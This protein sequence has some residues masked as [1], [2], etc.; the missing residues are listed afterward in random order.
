MAVD[1]DN[2]PADA[3]A[4]RPVEVTRPRD[5]V[6]PDEPAARPPGPPE[7]GPELRERQ[8]DEHARYRVVVEAT[9]KA[10][11]ARDEWERGSAEL[12]R[13]WEAYKERYPAPERQESRTEPDGS[14]IGDG[15]RRLSPEQNAEADKYAADLREEAVGSIRPAMER[16]QASDPGRKLAGLEHMLKG[17]DRLKEKLADDLNGY[18]EQ[19]VRAALGEIKDAVRF[20]LV[21]PSERYAEGVGQDVELLKAQGFELTRLKNLWSSDQYKGVNSQW[22]VPDTGTRFEMQFHTVESREAKELT[23]EAY[24]RIRS[25]NGSWVEERDAPTE[26]VLKDFQRRANMLLSKPPGAEAIRNFPRK[27]EQ[28]GA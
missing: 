20:S 26:G 5:T 2:E 24:E 14:W 10:T 28:A 18:P 12:R 17:E 15:Q 16:V 19:G 8:L 27:E 6:T 7:T 25:S 21:Y 1:R 11:A 4:R 22:Q 23:H 9:I 13:E 3:E